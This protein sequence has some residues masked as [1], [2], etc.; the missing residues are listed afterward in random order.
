MTKT[1]QLFY[2]AWMT[3]VGSFCLAQAP[4]SNHV[5]SIQPLHGDRKAYGVTTE[6][7]EIITKL[8]PER[9][10]PV[11]SGSW[12]DQVLTAGKKSAELLFQ[13]KFAERSKAWLY[14]IP[15]DKGDVLVARWN[16]IDTSRPEKTVWLW[17][18]PFYTTLV[19]E[20]D[21]AVLQ[22]DQFVPYCENLF[23]W[24]KAALI[25]SLQLAPLD[26]EGG[27]DWVLGLPEFHKTEQG[28]F[29]VWFIGMSGKSS[30][31]VG[32]GISKPMVTTGYP[33]EAFEIPER[34]PPLRVR[35]ANVP[36][37]ALFDELGK[38]YRGRL[39]MYPGNR[40]G[41]V[42]GEL[43][44]RGPLSD[45]ELREVAIGSFDKGDYSN[46]MLIIIRLGAFLRAA[47]WR[48]ELAVYAPSLERLLLQVPIHPAA[49][50]AVIGHVFTSMERNNIDFSHAAL[51]FLEHDRFGSQ[52]LLYL[53]RTA[54][55]EQTLRK[56]SDIVVNPALEAE[57]KTTLE[58]IKMKISF[59]P[60]R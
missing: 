43:L 18:T 32:I 21:R 42:M 26:S 46:A 44:S 17:D 57:R 11:V 34:F 60:S 29:H 19:L 22:G 38:G 12:E 25:T 14:T 28:S 39:A 6:L 48:N 24:G 37:R 15:M 45:V 8:D 4:N 56:L 54:S 16:E 2:F 36:R 51:A 1:K 10:R 5:S 50:G 35:L 27:K 20:V 7:E 33:P 59:P 13:L 47:E 23:V 9:L 52:S 31:Y 58:K 41:V 55:D 3:I 49:Q 30:A 40:D 53:G